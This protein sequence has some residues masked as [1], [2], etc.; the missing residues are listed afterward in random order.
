[1]SYTQRDF[2]HSKLLHRKLLH[3]SF[4]RQQLFTHSGL[5]AEKFLCKA[6]AHRKLLHTASFYTQK[7]FK[8]RR[9]LYTASF[10]TQQTFTHRAFYTESL[11]HAEAFIY[12]T[13]TEIAAPI[14]DPGATVTKGWFWSAFEK[15]FQ[16]E[17][18]WRQTCEKSAGKSLSQPW[19]SHAKTFFGAQWHKTMELRAAATPSSLDAAITVQSSSQSAHPACI[20]AHGN[21]AWPQVYSRSIATW[22]QRF[23]KRKKGTHARTHP[24]HLEATIIATRQKKSK[25][26]PAPLHKKPQCFMLRPPTQQKPDATSMQAWCSNLH[27]GKSPRIYAHGNTTWQQSCSHSAHPGFTS[28]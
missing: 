27:S 14:R 28:A 26:L 23:H 4:F 6:S 11:L 9:L 18:A 25:G 24:K 1:M 10:Y 19:R 20:C 21:T 15:K 13:A 22:N 8:R 16:K 17:N 5:Y 7:S 2:T 3:R 12:T